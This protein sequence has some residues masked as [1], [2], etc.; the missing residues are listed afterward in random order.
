MSLST[1]NTTEILCLLRTLHHATGF[2]ISNVERAFVL[3]ALSQGIRIDGRA[4][5]QF[6]SVELEFG[7]EYGTAT[8]KLGQTGYGERYTGLCI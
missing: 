5:D 1:R 3:E 7:D 8:V 4:L 6:R 2:D